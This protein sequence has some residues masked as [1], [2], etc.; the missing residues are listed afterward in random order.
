MKRLSLPDILVLLLLGF[1]IGLAVGIVVWDIARN[2]REVCAQIATLPETRWLPIILDDCTVDIVGDGSVRVPVEDY[3][4]ME[5]TDWWVNR[6]ARIMVDQHNSG[7]PMP[8]EW[9]RP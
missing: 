2:H 1:V 7:T 8:M 5:R 6:A 4:Q 3:L 9:C